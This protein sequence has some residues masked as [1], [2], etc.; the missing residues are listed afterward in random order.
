M[1]VSSVYLLEQNTIHLEIHSHQPTDTQ[2]AEFALILMG[3]Q[4][5]VDSKSHVMLIQNLG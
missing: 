1:L 2:A 3:H 4:K 5:A